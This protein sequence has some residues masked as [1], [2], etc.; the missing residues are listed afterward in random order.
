MPES[1]KASSYAGKILR[2][3]LSNGQIQKEDTYPYI[4]DWLG[5]AGI[6][7]KILFDELKAD[8]DPYDPE[9]IMIFGTG[10]LQGTTA[11]GSCKMT[12]STL[13]PMTG[14]WA[15]GA[16][17]SYIGGHIKRAGYDLVIL[18]GKA[19]HPIYLYI[20]DDVVEI[21]DAAKLWGKTTWET[22]DMLRE[23]F[24]NPSLNVICI[25]PAGENQVRGAC[26][27]QDKIRAFGRCGSGA[28][29]GSKNLKAIIV[30]GTKSVKVADP[31]RFMKAVKDIRKRIT[32]SETTKKYRKYGTYGAFEAKQDASSMNYKNFQ[33]AILPDDLLEAIDPRK[34]I[35]KYK[36]G[37]SC[38]PACPIGCGHV[39]QFKD[40]KYSGL[41]AEKSQW[42][43]FTTLQT[44]LAVKDPQFMIKANALANQLGIDVDMAGGSIGW[45]IECFEREII[46][47]E[48]TGGLELRWGGADQILQLM[49]MIS[50]RE[51]F[52]NLLAE[53]CARAS[54]VIGQG[55]EYYCMQIKKQEL[56]EPLR[57][58]MAWA[59]GTVVST[60][61]GGHTTGTPQM[62][63]IGKLDAEKMSKL[64]GIDPKDID[65]LGY[66][67]K[68]EIV[69]FTEALHR[70]A[71]CLGICQFNTIWVDFDFIGLPDMAELY[72]AATGIEI[73]VDE[74]KT[75]T[76]RQLNLEKIFNLRH[77]KFDRNDDMPTPRDLNEP[78]PTGKL[79][80]WRLEKDKWDQMLDRYYELH[81]WDKKTSYPTQ[82]TLDDLGIGYAYEEILKST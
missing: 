34:I 1:E 24:N 58:A 3:N 16:S 76:M 22:V 11:P 6:A 65:P 5:S 69:M 72:S 13:G 27:I 71:N 25:G 19:Q 31:D 52:G 2:V 41:K 66:E 82:K 12:I 63:T 64:Y 56:Y 32:S 55:S 43:V 29:M 28:V 59:L 74:L 70:A 42:E 60:R 78:I 7:I 14:G 46:S 8:T 68:P 57:G 51:G 15:T 21:R 80:G 26:I 81:G 61:G 35:E 20:N 23:D 44:R 47:V 67:G 4:K 37:R 18:T 9:N 10:V 33:E 36:V 39:V 48:D 79:A 62:E 49:E 77:A 38:F 73:S 45:A 75:I 53:G 17:D 40:G 30:N 50:H 54:Q